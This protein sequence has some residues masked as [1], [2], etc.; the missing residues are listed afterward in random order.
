[1][2]ANE[3]S[4]REI[5]L[6][7]FEYCVTEGGSIA[8]MAGM[9]RIGARW[10]GAH[11]G[12]M[13]GVLRGEWG[14]EG[15]VITDQASVAS[16]S[17]QDMISGLWAGTDLWLNTNSS[18]WSLDEWKDNAT[19]MSN[20]QRAASNVIYAVTN[21][22][23]V[24][25]YSEEGGGTVDTSSGMPAWKIWLIVLDVAVFAACAAGIVVPVVLYIKGRKQGGG[26]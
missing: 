1:M 7:G 3:Q 16:M 6:K 25:D 13:T 26:Q 20:V 12:I 22:N 8:A 14:F 10:V 23:A 11:K 4:I 21:S 19:V 9:N 17:Y 18:L 24:V 15:V 2:F 5:Y